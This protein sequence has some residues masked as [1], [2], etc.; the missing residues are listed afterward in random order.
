MSWW[1]NNRDVQALVRGSYMLAHAPAYHNGHFVFIGDSPSFMSPVFT[2][3]KTLDDEL[4]GMK[5]S[6]VPLSRY[7]LEH[8]DSAGMMDRLGTSPTLLRKFKFSDSCTLDPETKRVMR[9][10]LKEKGLDP[11]SIASRDGPT[12]LV[13]FHSMSR[14]TASL[15]HIIYEWAAQEAKLPGVPDDL[16][17]Q[18]EKKIRIPFIYQSPDERHVCVIGGPAFDGAPHG[19][20]KRL[21]SLFELMPKEAVA[22]FADV[23]ANIFND[24]A[25]RYVPHFPLNMKAAE[26]ADYLR[27]QGKSEEAIAALDIRLPAGETP[28]TATMRITSDQAE[29]AMY[30]TQLMEQQTR[31]MHGTLRTERDSYHAAQSGEDR[32]GD[33]AADLADE[34]AISASDAAPTSWADRVR[35]D[36]A[37]PAAEW[38]R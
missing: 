26:I 30:V 8:A 20:G 17:D 6:S 37:E 21:D 28:R 29:K 31:Q 36:A 1:D 19:W 2:T 12:V 9:H 34:N 7:F 16:A 32:G 24:D 14:G 4:S 11:Q 25:A 35:G 15:Y 22:P 23:M 38:A 10:L 5:V 13:D 18:V 33:S 3:A 27:Q